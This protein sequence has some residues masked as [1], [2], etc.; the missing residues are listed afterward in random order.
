MDKTAFLLACHK[1]MEEGRQNRGIGTLG[2]KTLHAVLK[3]YF[4]PREEHHEI[5][6]GSY[7]ADIRNEKG[8]FEIQTRGFDRLR[9]KLEVFLPEAPVTVIYP[10]PA[11][12]WLSWLEADG[13]ASPKRK[14]P[15]KGCAADI[16]PELYK[17]KPW[18]GR[19]GLSFC[20]VILVL[21]DYRLKN[22]WSKDRLRGS[23]RFERLPVDLLGEVWLRAPADYLAL[24]PENLAEEFTVKEYAKASRFSGKKA[25]VA[26]N[27]L[28]SMGVLKRV[29]KRKNAYL[30]QRNSEEK[31]ERLY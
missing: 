20:A 1:V 28:F 9:G 5:R 3:H 15:K 18:L 29:G 27:V 8:V 2:E 30:Y 12:K 25:S 7:V 16:L 26:V 6:V 4:D 10:V 31:N 11:I 19:Q 24:L 21:E 22:G 23:T 13:T 14:S 17:L